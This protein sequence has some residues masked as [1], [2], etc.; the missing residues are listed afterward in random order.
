MTPTG[1]VTTVAFWGHDAHALA[2]FYAEALGAK[3]TDV[4]GEDA[5]V[6]N[7][8]RIGYVFYRAKEFTPPNWPQDEL[9]FHFD[10]GFDDVEAAERRLIE[11]G[12]S[13]PDHQPGEGA[14][15]VLLDPSGQ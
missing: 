4:Y 15:T 1:Q 12:A 11:L 8:G 9:P 6:I 3:I 7:D 10:L 13:K 2:T 14:W 5:V